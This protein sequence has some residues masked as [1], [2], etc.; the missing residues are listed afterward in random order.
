MERSASYTEKSRS[1]ATVAGAGAGDLRCHSAYYVTSTYSAPPPPPLW[2]DDAGSG[3][4]SKIK[5]KKAAATWPSSSASASTSASKGRVWG[6]LGDA[7]EMQRRRRVAGYRVYGVEGKVKV[8]LQSSMRWIKG[9][10]TRVV[11][12]WW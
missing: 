6:G 9:K 11:D 4:A 12:G 10:C 2:Y 7:A 5:K 3:K 8:S 1:A